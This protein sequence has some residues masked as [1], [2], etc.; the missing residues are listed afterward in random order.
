MGPLSRAWRF[1]EWNLRPSSFT[2]AQGHDHLFWPQDHAWCVASEI[3]LFCTLVAGS[4]GLA[5]AL[6][7]DPRLE[8]WR[9]RPDDPIAY[10][11]DQVNA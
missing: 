4:D 8:A 7:G 11:S 2:P 5:E 9:V 3:D 10:D 1:F 6:V